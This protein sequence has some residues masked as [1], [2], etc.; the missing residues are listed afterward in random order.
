MLC[1]IHTHIGIYVFMNPVP[2]CCTVPSGLPIILSVSTAARSVHLKWEP[3]SFLNA[4]LV[5]YKLSWHALDGSTSPRQSRDIAK[6]DPS[7]TSEVISDLTPATRYR[8]EVAAI[9]MN[10]PGAAV[11]K[12]VT[13]QPRSQ[14]KWPSPRGRPP[15]GE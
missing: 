10:G 2:L 4:P 14:G 5:G 11:S 7:S 1:S 15:S 13:T 9:N 8:I 6:Q 12:V 3:P